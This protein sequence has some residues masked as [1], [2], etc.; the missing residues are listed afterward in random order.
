MIS[1]NCS[2]KA[3]KMHFA[4]FFAAPA[5]LMIRFYSKSVEAIIAA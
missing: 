4:F 2:K 3:V 5:R 1:I